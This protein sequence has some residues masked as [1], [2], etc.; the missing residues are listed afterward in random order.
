MLL[1]TSV[2]ACSAAA[3]SPRKP[4]TSLVARVLPRPSAG[5]IIRWAPSL[6]GRRQTIV[7]RA[8]EDGELELAVFRFTLGIPG[9]DDTYIPRVVGGFGLLLLLGNHLLGPDASAG[10]Q[11]RSEVLAAVLAA[12]CI[13]SPT[14]EARLKE[15][16]PGRGRQAAPQQVQGATSVFAISDAVSD[17]QK[18]ELAWASY[19]L[20]RNTNTCG[21]VVYSAKQAVMARG[22]IGSAAA[23]TDKVS[24]QACLERLSKEYGSIKS[25][26]ATGSSPDTKHLLYLQDKGAISSTGAYSWVGAVPT[27]AESIFVCEDTGGAGQGRDLLLMMLSDKP[28]AWS[29]RERAWGRAVSHKLS[30]TMS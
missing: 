19:A 3:G 4:G 18:Q 14:I 30:Q 28:R 22:A 1:S 13:A 23:S 12:L 5:P 16:E 8:A 20:L 9:F 25:Q 21:L 2:A 17:K 6:P 15:L 27:G 24:A 10:A 7:V 26:V 11:T 29:P